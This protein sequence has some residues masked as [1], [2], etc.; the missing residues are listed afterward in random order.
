[1]PGVGLL[2]YLF[3]GRGAH[4]FGAE[5]ILR[6]QLS[7]ATSQTPIRQLLAQQAAFLRGDAGQPHQLSE[8]DQRT[9]RLF[10]RNSSALLTIHNQVE[11]LQ[12]AREFYPRLLA[13]LRAARQSISL[14]YYIWESDAFTEE[15]KEILCAK[16]RAGVQVRGLYD[17]LGSYEGADQK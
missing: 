2:A 12:D 5:H 9:A 6:R 11:I 14:Q 7:D 3:F 16:A 17:W 13:D 10:M 1:M 4:A 15:I 8:T